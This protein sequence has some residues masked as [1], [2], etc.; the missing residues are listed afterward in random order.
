[1][2]KGSLE[3]R[4]KDAWLLTVWGP[5]GNGGRKRYRRTVHVRSRREAERALRSFAGEGFRVGVGCGAAEHR[6]VYL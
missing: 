2:G 6:V 5:D 3:K 1:M 4:G